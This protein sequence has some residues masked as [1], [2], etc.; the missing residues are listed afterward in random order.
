[1]NGMSRRLTLPSTAAAKAVSWDE[2]VVRVRSPRQHHLEAERPGGASLPVVVG[3]KPP[4]AERFHDGEMKAIQ[5]PAMDGAPRA[6]LPLGN[7]DRL[8]RA[9]CQLTGSRVQNQVHP[10][11]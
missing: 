2:Q 7:L 1:M 8:G 5:S 6:N 11:A 4:Q 9:G 10:P 3:E